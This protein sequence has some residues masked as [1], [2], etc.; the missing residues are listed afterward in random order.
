MKGRMACRPSVVAPADPDVEGARV[1]FAVLGVGQAGAFEDG[2]EGA[3]WQGGGGEVEGLRAFVGACEGGVAGAG[4]PE[5]AG[6][7]LGFEAAVF[8]AVAAD[9]GYAD[10]GAG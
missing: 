6:E 10:W 1:C 9:V 7:V 5:D 8:G 2:R 3:G 4:E